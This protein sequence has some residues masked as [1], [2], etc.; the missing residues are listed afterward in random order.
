MNENFQK[1]YPHLF[2]GSLGEQV[3]FDPGQGLVRIVI[4]LLNQ[5]QL[6]PLT[7]VQTRLHTGNTELTDDVEFKK[8]K[9]SDSCVA[10]CEYTL[11]DKDDHD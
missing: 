1:Q 9:Y 4:G 11:P 5:P 8:K 10:C 7:L 6:L 3:T 2:E